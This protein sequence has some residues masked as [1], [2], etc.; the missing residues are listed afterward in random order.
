MAVKPR[1][2]S[3]GTLVAI[4]VTVPCE[5]RL[6]SWR[7]SYWLVG[8]QIVGRY[9]CTCLQCHVTVSWDEMPCVLVD[10]RRKPK[11]WGQLRC[12]VF[13]VSLG[14][15]VRWAKSTSVMLP[16]NKKISLDV[17]L[18]TDTGRCPGVGLRPLACWDC[19]P[20]SRRGRECLSV[21]SV[22]CC[23]IEVSALGW[24][25]VQRSSTECTVFECGCEASIMRRPWPTGGCCVVE[26][27]NTVRLRDIKCILFHCT[28][29]KDVG[30]WR[31]L[32]TLLFRLLK[33]DINHG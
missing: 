31:Y 9:Q 5:W 2:L 26:K 3:Y 19:G 27:K 4:S 13:A 10:M 21:V 33:F 1:H 20:E 24:L 16:V 17:M 18:L 15:L 12:L 30:T 29:C 6:Y 8:V 22:V 7:K 11:F 14:S 28:L 25:L 23:Q 32:L